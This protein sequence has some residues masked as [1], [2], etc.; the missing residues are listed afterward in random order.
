MR[1]KRL[2]QHLNPLKLTALVPRAPLT[3][4]SGRPIDVELGCADARCLIE[5][6]RKSAAKRDLQ[7]FLRMTKLA[8]DS[9]RVTEANQLLQDL[10]DA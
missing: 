6:G 8:Y 4:P 1:R 9:P 3:L 10:R 7:D 5:L 2:R